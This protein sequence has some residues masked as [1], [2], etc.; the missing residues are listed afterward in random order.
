MATI[1]DVAKEAGVSRATVTR[2]LQSPNLVASNTREK[3]QAAIKKL[4]YRP[5][6]LSQTFRN[7]RSNTLV[8]MTPN[9]ANPL[10]AKIVS[11]IEAV[12]Q[13]HGY[14]LLLGDTHNSP[15]LEDRYI[16][17]VETQLADGVIQLGC[18]QNSASRLYNPQLKAVGI[19]GI[20]S[21]EH[22]EFPMVHIDGITASMGDV[23]STMAIIAAAVEEQGSATSEISRNAQYA[24]DGTQQAV[25]EAEQTTDVASR[26]NKSALDAQSATEDLATRAQSL[27][28]R[29]ERF[30]QDV[31]T[32]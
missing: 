5:N 8:V 12:A 22:P 9:N 26:T 20:P 10:F 2:V 24:A 27:Q 19:A 6:M 1:R 28:V 32:G 15:K 3:V 31:A 21:V 17:L 23:S 18:Y 16:G 4:D 7:K 13:E 14:N 30:M 29:V 11:G 25:Q